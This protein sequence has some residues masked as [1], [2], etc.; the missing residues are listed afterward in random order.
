M[1][2]KRGG[3]EVTLHST[4]MAF[5][6]KEPFG[7]KPLVS[8]VVGAFSGTSPAKAAGLEVG[9]RILS[10]NATAVTQ[11]EQMPA[12]IQKS[13]GKPVVLEVDR[14]GAHRTITVTP[15]QQGGNWIVG[16]SPG[17]QRERYGFV[18]AFARGSERLWG[19]TA[20]TF[21]FLGQ[22]LTGRGS[23]DALGGPVK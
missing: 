18:D 8:P 2:V 10:I 20:G 11:W 1:T 17:T 19:M 5:A 21:K 7:W 3:K 6:T 13:A 9:D 15:V 23:L 4:A 16:I 12:A 22:M 14:N